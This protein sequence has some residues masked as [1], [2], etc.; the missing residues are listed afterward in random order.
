MSELPGAF[1]IALTVS[2]PLARAQ[3]RTLP[4]GV[5][6]WLFGLGWRFF[7]RRI[8][9]HWALANAERLRFALGAVVVCSGLASAATLGARVWPL[10]LAKAVLG[11]VLG[12]PGVAAAGAYL[13]VRSE[14]DRA[15][16]RTLL[17]RPFV[18]GLGWLSA[19]G[20]LTLVFWFVHDDL[21]R[22]GVSTLL[23]LLGAACLA[24]FT[25]GGVLQ[26]HRNVF[27]AAD[28]H[29]LMPP[30]AAPWLCLG[31]VAVELAMVGVQPASLA[32]SG[33]AAAAVVA[34]CGWEYRTGREAY[35]ISART[36]PPGLETDPDTGQ[37]WW[38]PVAGPSYSPDR[39]R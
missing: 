15:Y 29:P 23:L 39:P 36:G 19:A 37:V 33:A 9:G 18:V 25:L 38:S 8:D 5:S 34:V 32:L 16:A 6:G 26:I 11:P 13:L 10:I 20:V 12:T 35:G 27:A 4:W 2:R 3:L 31:A 21:R 17:R 24:P 22:L 14:G 7:A 28:G 1:N 30:L